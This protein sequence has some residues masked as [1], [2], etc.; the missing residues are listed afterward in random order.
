V[1]DALAAYLGTIDK[2]LL[3]YLNE[4]DEMM[5]D[6]VERLRLYTSALLTDSMT[7]AA[8]NEEW[9]DWYALTTAFVFAYGT[10]QLGDRSGQW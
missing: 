3:F 10:E 7:P 9:P 4:D 1:N 2:R 8:L 5:F 6:T